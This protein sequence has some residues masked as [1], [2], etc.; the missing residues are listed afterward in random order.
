MNDAFELFAQVFDGNG[1]VDVKK[2]GS[3]DIGGLAR[4]V[5]KRVFD[6]VAQR[7][8]K[9]AEIPNFDDDVG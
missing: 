1:V 3:H 5:L 8:D 6:E 4:P 9:A 7:D 2:G